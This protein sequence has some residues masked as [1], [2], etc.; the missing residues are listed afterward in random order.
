MDNLLQSIG[1]EVLKWSYKTDCC[2]GGLSFTRTEVSLKLV[3]TLVHAA[4]EAGANCIVT[5]CPL[6]QSNLDNGQ[7]MLAISG[8]LEK[9]LPVFYITELMT[10][11][12][13]ENAGKWMSTH[14]I[15]PRPLLGQL[16]IS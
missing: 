16:N 13:G 15:D 10:I 8:E 11:S 3:K 12:F 4:L 2:G 14:M 5:A 1:A 6:C 7:R 9:T